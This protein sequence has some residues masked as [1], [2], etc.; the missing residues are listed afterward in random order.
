MPRSDVE[1]QSEGTTCRGWLYRGA[2]PF[3]PVVLAERLYIPHATSWF[4]EH[5]RP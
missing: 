1:F 3:P 5:L 4:A 2:G